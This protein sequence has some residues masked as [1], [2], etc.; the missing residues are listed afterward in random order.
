MSSNLTD[1]KS[2]Y[3]EVYG[4]PECIYCGAETQLHIMEVPICIKCDNQLGRGQ[5]PAPRKGPEPVTA[6]NSPSKQGT[7]LKIPA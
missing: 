3:L 5:K 1:D 7:A 2:A 4:M 6:N